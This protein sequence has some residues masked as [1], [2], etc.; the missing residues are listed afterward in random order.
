MRQTR[1]GLA[2]IALPIVGIALGFCGPARAWQQPDPNTPEGMQ[3]LTQGP[4]HE[5]FAEPVL[6]DP[7]PGP[8]VPKAPP[9]PIT[10]TPPEQKPEGAYVQWIPGYWAW[11]DVRNDYIWVSGVWRAIPPGHQWIPGYWQQVTGGYQWVPGYW[12]STETTQVQYLPE[13]P[14]SLEK[15][16]TSPPP[17]ENATWAPGMWVWQDNQYVWRPGFWVENQPGW[18]WYPA[19]YSWSPSGYVYNQGYWDYPLA[20][21]GIPFAPVYFSQPIYGQPGF[22]YSPSVGLLTSA[23]LNSL[24]VR[25]SYGSYYFGDYY[26]PNNFQSGFYPWYA[27]HGSRYG[28]D[29]LYAYTAAQHVRSNPRWADELLQVYNYR[30]EHPEA[31]PAQTFDRMRSLVVRPATGANAATAAAT[32]LMLARPFNQ[33]GT[34]AT[35]AVR[36]RRMTPRGPC[37]SSNSTPPG[38]RSSPARPPSC[39]SSATSVS[40]ASE[41]SAAARRERCGRRRDKWSGPVPRSSPPPRAEGPRVTP[42]ALPAHPAV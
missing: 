3:V 1:W 26:A 29:P 15:G 7:K 40:S 5:A 31:R 16:P 32:N 9:A 39:T 22:A 14:A 10:E 11:D 8:I 30:R 37:G 6:Y 42:P 13:P 24:F 25:P 20:N 28:Y 17:S 27:F 38:V 21:R 19:S 12:G 4:I 41:S 33:F 34:P 18:M 35:G 2:V 23:L 36:G